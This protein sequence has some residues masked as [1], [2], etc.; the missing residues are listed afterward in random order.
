MIFVSDSKNV[1]GIRVEYL[2]S[3]S[4]VYCGCIWGCISSSFDSNSVLMI[5][6]ESLGIQSTFRL[7]SD[8]RGR[9]MVFFN[10][11][12]IQVFQS[13]LKRGERV[14]LSE[15]SLAIYKWGSGRNE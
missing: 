9:R 3:D 1:S 10:I 5:T 13:G 7:Q 11:K 6:R 4:F 8:Q 2:V 12:P 15:T 14:I